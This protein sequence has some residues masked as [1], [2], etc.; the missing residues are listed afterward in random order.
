LGKRIR[1]WNIEIRIYDPMIHENIVRPKT[2]YGLSCSY[3]P[4]PKQFETK[5]LSEE[6]TKWYVHNLAVNVSPKVIGPQCEINKW[7]HGCNES[8]E[9]RPVKGAS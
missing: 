8:P 3:V 4:L 5:M 9:S 2:S 1:P 6:N 7:Y